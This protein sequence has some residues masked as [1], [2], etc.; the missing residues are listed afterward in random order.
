[1]AVSTTKG[2]L[3]MNGQ[4][5]IQSTEKPDSKAMYFKSHLYGFMEKAQ[6]YTQRRDQRLPKV[7]DTGNWTRMESWRKCASLCH[8]AAVNTCTSTYTKWCELHN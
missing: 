2:E 1:M 6:Q 5:P 4:R 3:S 7:R 8:H